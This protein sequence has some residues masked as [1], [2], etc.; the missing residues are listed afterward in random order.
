VTAPLEWESG[1][2]APLFWGQV[3]GPE[4]TQGPDFQLD[5]DEAV[6]RSRL[7][8]AASAGQLEY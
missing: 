7:E 8:A 4:V 1:Q 3:G 2:A 6:S 5:Q